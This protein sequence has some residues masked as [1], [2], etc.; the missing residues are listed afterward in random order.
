[1]KNKPAVVKRNKRAL[2]ILG[3]G[4]IL[5]MILVAIFAP[6]LSHQ[7]P[8][9]MSLPDRF[10]PPAFSHPFGLDQNGSDIYSKVVYGARISIYVSL[11]VVTICLIVG[12]IMGSIAGY[13]GGYADLIVMRFIDM[14]Y[15]FPGFLLAIALVAV[16]GPSVHNLIFAMCTTGWTGY[17]RLV[18]GEFLHLKSKEYVQSAISLGANPLRVISLH[19][20]PN[21]T[22]PLVVQASFGMAGT[23][24]AESSLSFLG[25]GTPPTE[26]SWGGLLN[27][28]RK[29]L[30][31]APFIS[32]FPGVAIILLVLGFNLFGDGLRD[33]LDPKKN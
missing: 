25:L 26:P 16:L 28:G 22:G 14:L 8:R 10:M 32:I 6:V 13:F 11:T 12:L 1:M 21:L 4:L 30:V 24:L 17:A 3:G 19:I 20:W 9:A 27:A 29:F 15:A 5:F 31:E 33:Y 23:I 2:I 7:D 18:R